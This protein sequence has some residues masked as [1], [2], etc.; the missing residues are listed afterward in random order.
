LM[1]EVS[2]RKENDPKVM[3]RQSCQCKEKEGP[4]LH[5]KTPGHATIVHLVDRRCSTGFVFMIGGG[6]ISWS[7]K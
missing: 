1:H 4:H 3:M 2:K 7:S 5:A 6:A